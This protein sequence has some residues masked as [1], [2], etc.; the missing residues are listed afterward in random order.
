MTKTDSLCVQAYLTVDIFMVLIHLV[1]GLVLILILDSSGTMPPP[2]RCVFPALASSII[3]SKE[4][5]KEYH[6]V[7]KFQ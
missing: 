5:V 4:N 6:V 2:L 1:L 7:I 3:C